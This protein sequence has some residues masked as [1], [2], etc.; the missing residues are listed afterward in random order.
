MFVELLLDMYARVNEVALPGGSI[1]VPIKHEVGLLSRM[2]TPAARTILGEKNRAH[3]VSP[4]LAVL[5][6][7]LQFPLRDAGLLSPVDLSPSSGVVC[8]RPSQG[9]H[10]V[11]DEGTPCCAGS[12]A[13]AVHADT[14][15]GCPPP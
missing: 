14:V 6:R 4:A 15:A 8:G 13:G 10:R 11:L 12:A 7:L 2:R 9:A 1:A 5:P 3:H